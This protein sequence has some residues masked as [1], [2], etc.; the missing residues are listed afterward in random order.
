[1]AVSEQRVRITGSGGTGI[2]TRTERNR[3]VFRLAF[4][5]SGRSLQS[6][7][8]DFVDEDVFLFEIHELADAFFHCVALRVAVATMR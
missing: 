8:G 4:H 2:Q 5:Y 1:V 6:L 3:H 7:V